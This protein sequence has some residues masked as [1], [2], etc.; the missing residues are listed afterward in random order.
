MNAFTFLNNQKV[1]MVQH[2]ASP[3]IKYFKVLLYTRS[4][5][6]TRYNFG[7]D[8]GVARGKR[9]KERVT[10]EFGETKEEKILPP[11]SGRYTMVNA[12]AIKGVQEYDTSLATVIDDDFVQVPSYDSI[13]YNHYV[14]MGRAVHVDI[15]C[16]EGKRE[17]GPLCL[18]HGADE[19]YIFDPSV[20]FL[21]LSLVF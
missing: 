9:E 7:K 8:Q 19:G 12:H 6:K 17:V 5:A 16:I 18:D 13:I 2:G 15:S 1:C 11:N 14:Y 3:K 21:I 10:P 20:I 4:K